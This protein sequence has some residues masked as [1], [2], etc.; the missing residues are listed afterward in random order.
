MGIAKRSW[1]LKAAS[2]A[3]ICAA[4]AT[5]LAGCSHC[6]WCRRA[7]CPGP[8]YWRVT[9]TDFEGQRISEYIAE[10]PVTETCDGICIWALQRRIF[11]PYVLT[12]RYPLG[13][14]V[15]VQGSNII[16]A[17]ICSPTNN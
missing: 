10:G 4:I 12:F 5:L 16:V 7:P 6:C 11:H 2:R 9:L 8:K 17:S 13:R 1:K 3:T 14:P 15:K